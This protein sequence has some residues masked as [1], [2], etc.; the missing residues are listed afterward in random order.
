[1]LSPM[2][3]LNDNRWT[4]MRTTEIKIGGIYPAIPALG[5][6]GQLNMH[7]LFGDITTE[8]LKLIAIKRGIIKLH[9]PS[10]KRTN[11]NTPCSITMF[12]SQGR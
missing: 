11:K 10:S 9:M 2:L 7:K 5:I 3:G 4:G 8:Q 12:N 6:A 1:M